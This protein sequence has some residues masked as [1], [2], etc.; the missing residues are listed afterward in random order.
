[1]YFCEFLHMCA[2]SLLFGCKQKA[3]LYGEIK[4]FAS[5]D[6]SLG[7]FFLSSDITEVEAVTCC[8]T[9]F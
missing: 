5:T 9:H 1:M 4:T 3:R 7:V 6:V 8:F 2:A